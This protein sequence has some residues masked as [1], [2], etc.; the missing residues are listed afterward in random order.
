MGIAAT[1]SIENG[2]TNAFLDGLEE[3]VEARVVRV[4]ALRVRAQEQRLAVARVEE[5][6]HRVGNGFLPFGGGIDYLAVEVG[7]ETHAI[8]QADKA[9]VRRYRRSACRRFRS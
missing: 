6:P 5:V 7:P 3:L 8:G 1:V 4:Q 2:D 9:L